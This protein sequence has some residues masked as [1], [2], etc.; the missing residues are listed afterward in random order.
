[1]NGVVS[2]SEIYLIIQGNTVFLVLYYRI[3]KMSDNK[4]FQSIESILNK[5]ADGD[6]ENVLNVLYGKGTK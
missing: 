5:L 6:R 4:E 1:M 2:L 3:R